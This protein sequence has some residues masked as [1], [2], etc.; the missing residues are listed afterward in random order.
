MC[1][2][3]H[4]TVKRIVGG[5]EAGRER[6]DR[7]KN[8]DSVRGLVAYGLSETKGKISALRLL[9]KARAAGYGGSDRNFRRLVVQEHSKYRQGV[10]IARV[11]P[12]GGLAPR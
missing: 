10:A 12:A 1:G 11:P 8:Y 6:V 5:E 7:G 9:P 2:V 3:T 4:K